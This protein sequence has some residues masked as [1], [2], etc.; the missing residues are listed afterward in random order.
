[1]G[2]GSIGK[3][4]EWNEDVLLVGDQHQPGHEEL[5]GSSW[6]HRMAPLQVSHWQDCP[7]GVGKATSSD[8]EASLI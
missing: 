5:W 3:E 8:D 1:V 2:E 6:H 7:W 4:R